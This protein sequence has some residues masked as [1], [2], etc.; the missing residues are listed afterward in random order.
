VHNSERKWLTQHVAVLSLRRP[1]FDPSAAHV[2]FVV[3]EVA[4]GP[5]VILL[6]RVSP[7][8]T[9]LI[10]SFITDPV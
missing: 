8:S 10:H 7:V 3:D 9:I 5:V 1:A 6:L 4:L 2:E